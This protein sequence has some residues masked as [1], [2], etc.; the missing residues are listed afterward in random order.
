MLPRVHESQQNTPFLT[1]L[2]S[3][4]RSNLKDKEKIA[5]WAIILAPILQKTVLEYSKLK[6]WQ[7]IQF[8][9]LPYCDFSPGLKDKEKIAVWAIILAPILQKTVLEYSKLKKW[10]LIQFFE[11]PY[12]DF[13]PGL[14]V[15]PPN[16][17][18]GQNSIVKLFHTY[19]QFWPMFYTIPASTLLNSIYLPGSPI[20]IEKGHFF[21]FERCN[22]NN[23]RLEKRAKKE[24]FL[25]GR[26]LRWRVCDDHVL[27]I[28]VFFYEWAKR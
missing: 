10:Q 15:W 13:S 23:K 8:F 14:K 9:E 25:K 5:V 20:E 16:S 28:R 2:K 11:L 12:C 1:L 19:L 27:Y 7:L 26:A 3:I 17:W 24:R 21:C 6:K 4:G 22:Y 18:P